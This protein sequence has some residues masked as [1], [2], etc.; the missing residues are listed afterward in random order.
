[1]QK[2]ASMTLQGILNWEREMTDTTDPIVRFVTEMAVHC[3]AEQLEELME[4]L[5]AIPSESLEEREE[6]LVKLVQAIRYALE[7]D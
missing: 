6:R 4:A 7:S 2:R 3:D 1:M 5:V